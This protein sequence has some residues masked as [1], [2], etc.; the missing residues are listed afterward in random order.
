MDRL[1]TDLHAHLVPGVDDGSR[2]SMETISMAKGLRGLG[3][4]RV[5][6]TPHQF[7]FGNDFT[8]EELERMAAD[9]RQLLALALVELEVVAGAEYCYGARLLDALEHDE[10]LMT[11]RFGD[12]PCVLIELPLRQPVAGVRNVAAA[13]RRRGIRP[14]M[15]HPERL[16][17]SLVNRDR[18]LGWFQAGWSFQVNL[19]SFVGYHGEEAASL[20][21]EMLREGSV[22]GVG[23]D[24]HRPSELGLLARAFGRYRQLASA[25]AC[26]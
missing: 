25:E 5:H 4:R 11:F 17:R 15:A 21:R 3:I 13:L 7:R 23:S 8:V 20:A 22:L 1:R 16:D 9:V 18:V 14:V 10:E 26:P 6:V 12:E 2:S 24:I 19:L